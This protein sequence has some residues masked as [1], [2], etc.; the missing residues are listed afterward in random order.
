[1]RDEDLKNLPQTIAGWQVAEMLKT[2]GITE[3]RNVREVLIET[4][5]IQ[6][7]VLAT[8]ERGQRYFAEHVISIPFVGPWEK[9]VDVAMPHDGVTAEVCGAW[10]KLGGRRMECQLLAGHEMDH[11]YSKDTGRILG[12][13]P[14][15]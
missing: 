6:V 9:P 14:Q 4:R 11:D 10:K 12:D 3:Y 2:I 1:M 13:A 15:A 5:R 7:T 8:G